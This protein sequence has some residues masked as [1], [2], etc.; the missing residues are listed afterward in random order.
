MKSF[1]LIKERL[2][3]TDVL[4]IYNPEKEAILET[5]ILDYTIG[6]YLA[7]NGEDSKRRVVAYYFRKII[8]LEYT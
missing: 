3:S 4:A 2:C 7:Q 1:N 8:G 5:D 6:T